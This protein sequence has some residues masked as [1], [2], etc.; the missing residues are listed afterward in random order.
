M[1]PYEYSQYLLEKHSGD[2]EAAFQEACENIAWLNRNCISSGYIRRNPK[3]ASDTR[4]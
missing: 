3:P 4:R 2:V 1:T